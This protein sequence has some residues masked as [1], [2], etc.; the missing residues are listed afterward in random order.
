ME[1]QEIRILYE[2][3]VLATPQDMEGVHHIKSLPW[4]SVVQSVKGSYDIQIDEREP[5]QTGEGGFFLAAS[6]VTQSILHHSDPQTGRMENRWIFLDILINQKYRIDNLF[7]FPTLLPQREQEEMNRLF[8]EL[9]AVREDLCERMSVYYRIIKVLLRIAVP[10][11]LLGNEAL[12]SVVHHLHRHYAEPIGV[13]ELASIA[14]MSES[15]L[16]ASF[17]RQFG[18]S[19]IAYL[20]H[21][22]LT[23]ASDLLKQTDLPVAKIAERV[24]FSDPLYFSKL[25]HKTFRASPRQYRK[26]VGE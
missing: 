10:K 22:R 26:L 15:N 7:D 14:H 20:N 25:F 13:S 6:Q 2:R 16:Y 3:C 23:L 9:F 8:D 18:T 17:K 4:L 19:P 5:C 21:Y 24:G 12:L 11:K 1:I